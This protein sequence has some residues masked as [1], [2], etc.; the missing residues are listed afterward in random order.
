MEYT[1]YECTMNAEND[2]HNENGHD[3][4]DAQDGHDMHDAQN[5]IDHLQ[6]NS[7]VTKKQTS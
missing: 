3:M 1:A 5:D 6:N 7:P 4:R 2:L